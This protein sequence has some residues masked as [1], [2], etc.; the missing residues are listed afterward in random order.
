VESFNSG[1]YIRITCTH[2]SLPNVAYSYLLILLILCH[3]WYFATLFIC[4]VLLELLSLSRNI[5]HI[6]FLYAVWIDTNLDKIV[7]SISRR[8]SMALHLKGSRGMLDWRN[9]YGSRIKMF[10][11][12]FGASS[13]NIGYSSRIF[14][15]LINTLN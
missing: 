5:C 15:Y 14:W 7:T 2:H 8:R 4:E 3:K 12:I 1:R 9:R 11:E 13:D 6:F 10:L